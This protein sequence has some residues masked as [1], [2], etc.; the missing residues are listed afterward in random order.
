MLLSTNFKKKSMGKSVKLSLFKNE[1]DAGKWKTLHQWLRSTV[2]AKYNTNMNPYFSL[3]T[4]SSKLT[5]NDKN[6]AVTGKAYQE[7]GYPN[8]SDWSPTTYVYVYVCHET[9]ILVKK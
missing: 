2:L 8:R 3:V 1:T 6:L 9:R 4:Y 7:F 5:H